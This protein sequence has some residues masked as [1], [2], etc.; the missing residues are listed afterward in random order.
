VGCCRCKDLCR[1]H[2]AEG[3]V[4]RVSVFQ[5]RWARCACPK[6][7]IWVRWR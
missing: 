2:L 4:R 3:P 6:S 1:P 7:S 5:Y